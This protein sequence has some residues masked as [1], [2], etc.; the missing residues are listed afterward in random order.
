MSEDAFWALVD[1]AKDW[2]EIDAAFGVVA[3]NWRPSPAE[4][5]EIALRMGDLGRGS[6]FSDPVKE[7]RIHDA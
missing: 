3:P 5:I 2:R 7:I 6:G 1:N 4:I